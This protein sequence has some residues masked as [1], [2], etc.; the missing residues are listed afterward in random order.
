[1]LTLCL[2]ADALA[3][4]SCLLS[5]ALWLGRLRLPLGSLWGRFLAGNR[6]LE[7][8]LLLSEARLLSSLRL[9]RLCGGS[10]ACWLLRLCGR[11][12]GDAS[13]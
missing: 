13:S 12:H 3:S 9:T 7:S 4:R 8:G 1:M 10:T 2:A 11:L 6:G 5:F